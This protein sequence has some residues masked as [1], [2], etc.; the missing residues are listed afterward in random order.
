MA[1]PQATGICRTQIL[2]PLCQIFRGRVEPWSSQ[3][4]LRLL[5]RDCES[6]EGMATGLVGSVWDS[7]WNA[8]GGV[9][10]LSVTV[11]IRDCAIHSNTAAITGMGS[12]G[13]IHL[14]FRLSLLADNTIHD[15]TASKGVRFE[16]GGVGRTTR[17]AIVTGNTIWD[18]VANTA[19]TAIG[20]G[21]QL[22]TG[23]PTLRANVLLRDVASRHCN[24]VLVSQTMGIRVAGECQAALNGAPPYAN[25]GGSTAVSGT[26]A[27]TSEVTAFLALAPD[28]Y[29]VERLSEALDPGVESGVTGDVDGELRPRE[30]SHRMGP[31][32][33][34][35]GISADRRHGNTNNRDTLPLRRMLLARQNWLASVRK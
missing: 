13:G 12:S 24:T 21:L 14:L 8:G 18:N 3:A 28:G 35:S 22:E 31:S 6:P 25:P 33:E 19:G 10:M 29:H 20:G 23:V 9:C 15:N 30:T 1:A 7:T 5:Y 34:G 16:T 17:Y 27:A 26:T 4:R 2:T 32:N 11:T